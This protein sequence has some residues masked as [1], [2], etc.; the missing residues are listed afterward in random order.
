[1]D[2][3]L[4]GRDLGRVDF[5]LFGNRAPKTVNNFLGFVSGDFDP[6]LRYKGSYLLKIHE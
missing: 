2:F 3:E 6:Y 4:E 1:M 5:E